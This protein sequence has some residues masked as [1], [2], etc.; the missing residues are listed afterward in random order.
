[1]VY[2]LMKKKIRVIYVERIDI[3]TLKDHGYKG[4]QNDHADRQSEII[5]FFGA[6]I[7][8]NDAN[9]LGNDRGET[10]AKRFPT[11]LYNCFYDTD[12][13]K[14]QKRRQ[15]MIEPQFTDS[16]RQVTVS[17]LITFKSLY[18]AYEECRISIPQ[19]DR[20]VEE[21]VK[22]NCN[23][24]FQNQVDDN[25]NQFEIV[26]KINPSDHYSH[27]SNY[28]NIG[29][30]KLVNNE[31]VGGSIGIIT[32]ESQKKRLTIY[33]QKKEEARKNSLNPDLE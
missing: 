33:E 4:D 23:I 31:R 29:I 16:K 18:R 27:A 24:A 8:I 12:E 32:G 25:G 11:R 20:E 5:S 15:K 14:K 21:F 19:I 17:R 3:D 28:A 2:R 6:K 22:H 30:S 10:L 7:V 26:G 13:I 1:M 9:G